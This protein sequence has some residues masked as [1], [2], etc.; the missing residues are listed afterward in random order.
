MKQEVVIFDIDG[1]LANC[2]HRRG[3]VDGTNGEKNWD[4]FF[5]RMSDDDP[6]TPTFDF[7]L[8]LLRLNISFIFVTGRPEKYREQTFKWLG[9]YCP[10]I[11]GRLLLMRKNDDFRSDT[12]V[13]K[14]IYEKCIKPHFKVK[15]VLDDRDSVVEMWRSLGLTCWQVAKGNF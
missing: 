7:L 2:D 1:T 10:Y 3:W 14:E 13:K 4:E 9:K 8:M 6:I 15:L 5:K 11:L 12:E